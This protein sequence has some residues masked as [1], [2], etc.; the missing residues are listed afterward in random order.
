[1]HAHT[2]THMHK[3]HKH[4][5]LP[6]TLAHTVVTISVA[7]MTK[8][9][10]KVLVVSNDD[11]LEVF[12]LASLPGV[13]VCVCV[14]VCVHACMRVCACACVRVRVCV[15]GCVCACVWVCV[16]VRACVCVYMCMYVY[17]C[18]CVKKRGIPSTFSFTISPWQ[19]LLL[20]CLHS[21]SITVYPARMVLRSSRSGEGSLTRVGPNTRATLFRVI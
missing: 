11:E 6:Y 2:H 18:A 19:S 5:S 1:M 17:V 4:H 20:T 13:C 16:C 12:L 3:H 10:D 15:W 8:K 9:L 7:G 21:S 14:C